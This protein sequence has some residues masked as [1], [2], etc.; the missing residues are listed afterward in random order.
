MTL[1]EFNEFLQNNTVV[2]KDSWNKG[3]LIKIYKHA[4][5]RNGMIILQGVKNERRNTNSNKRK[6]PT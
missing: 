5:K 2:T 3:L 1:K 4:Y 6:Q